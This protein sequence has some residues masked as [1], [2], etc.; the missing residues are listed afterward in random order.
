MYLSARLALFS[1]KHFFLHRTYEWISK[2]NVFYTSGAN[3][4]ELE[5]DDVVLVQEMLC[6]NND[7]DKEYHE[8]TGPQITHRVWDVADEDIVK[9]DIVYVK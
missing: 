1:Q 7:A 9:I 6:D 2:H 8:K 4:A 3:I 5:E